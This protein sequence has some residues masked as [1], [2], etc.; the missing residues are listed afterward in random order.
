[1]TLNDK[2]LYEGAKVCLEKNPDEELCIY[3]FLFP[4]EVKNQNICKMIHHIR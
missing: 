1:M 2:A 4:K 3:Q